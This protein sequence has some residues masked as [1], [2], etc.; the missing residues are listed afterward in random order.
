MLAYKLDELANAEDPVQLFYKEGIA[1][2][3]SAEIKEHGRLTIN[4]KCSNIIH[5]SRNYWL[6]II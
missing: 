1:Q 4:Y 6:N 2:T 5:K 3:I